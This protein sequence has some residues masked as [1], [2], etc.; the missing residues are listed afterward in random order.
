MKLG[1]YLFFYIFLSSIFFEIKGQAEAIPDS[2]IRI[3]GIVQDVQTK[4]PI[5]AVLTY[6][7][8]PFKNNVGI[9]NTDAET[10]SYS[11]YMIAGREYNLQASAK[12]YLSQTEVIVVS[13]LDNDGVLQ[14]NFEL[15]PITVGRVMKL[16]KLFFEQSTSVILEESY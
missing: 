7:L 9:A 11:L 10:G 8:L 6:Q 13:D 12:G 2:L 1:L 5:A 14:I 4:Q 15:M 16:N 3:Q